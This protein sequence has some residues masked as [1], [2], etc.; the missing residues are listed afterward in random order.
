MAFRR[1]AGRIAAI[2]SL[3][4]AVTQAGCVQSASEAEAVTAPVAAAEPMSEPGPGTGKDAAVPAARILAMGDSMVAWH[5]VSG[6]SL[7]DVLADDLG[8]PV[9]NRAVGAARIVYPLPITGALGL[10]IAKQYRGGTWDWVVMNGGGNDI[11]LGCGC[12]ACEH[13]V[14]RMVSETGAEGMIPD[15]MRDIRASGARVIYLG[16]LRSPGVGSIIDSCL[17]AGN[18]FE[19]RLARMAEADPGIYFLSLADLVP[20][21]DRSFHGIDMIHPSVKGSQ[22]IA[23]RVAAL[24]KK[25]DATR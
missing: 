5:S 25:A 21:G 11:F 15:L 18:R 8:E 9:V 3:V 2:I 17:P 16:Y 7:A 10:N 22:A 23:H 13:K 6:R 19:A 20:E 12:K 24:I 1:Q 14:D 4:V